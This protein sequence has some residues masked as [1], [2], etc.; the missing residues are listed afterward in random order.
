MS[1]IVWNAYRPFASRSSVPAGSSAIDVYKRQVDHLLVAERTGC[2]WPQMGTQ[3]RHLI[4]EAPVE[5]LPRAHV[6]ALV[7]IG[8][9]KVCLF[10][11]SSER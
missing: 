6:T 4:H 8:T 5:H 9:V 11:T 3:T 1:I 10:Y 2:G 7:Q